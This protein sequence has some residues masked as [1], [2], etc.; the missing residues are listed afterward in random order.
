MLPRFTAHVFYKKNQPA[1]HLMID[2]GPLI[3]HIY[4]AWFVVTMN[5]TS[6]QIRCTASNNC[7][8]CISFTYE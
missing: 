1:H 5:G 4:K 2:K 3:E 6:V 7:E 8:F